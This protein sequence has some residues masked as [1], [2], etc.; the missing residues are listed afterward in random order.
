MASL[1]PHVAKVLDRQQPTDSD[2]EDARVAPLRGSARA[3]GLGLDGGRD[4]DDDVLAV[5]VDQDP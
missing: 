2:D 4:Y 3:R 5:D 1:D